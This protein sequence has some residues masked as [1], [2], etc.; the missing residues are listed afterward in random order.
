MINIG[1]DWDELLKG[2][3]EKPYYL[4]LREFL[5]NEY[6]TKIIYPNM[7]DIFNALKYTSYKDTK[8]LILGQDPYHGENQAHGLAFSVKP[9]VKTPPSLLNMYKELNSEYGCFIPNNGFLVPWTEQGVLLLNTA[10]T[11]RAHEANSHKGK[12]WEIFTDNIIK[13]LNERHD[14]VIFVLWGNNARSKKKL[15]DTQKHYII[16]SAHPSPLSASRGFF[17]SK[18]FSKINEI[19]ISLGKTPIDW[20][21]PNI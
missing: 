10:L 8:V 14:P 17:G 6:S 15:I 12:G 5:K 11:V 20:Q 9:G 1:N 3:F 2:E 21:I 19:L 16:E 7:Y 13:L 18:P 4:E